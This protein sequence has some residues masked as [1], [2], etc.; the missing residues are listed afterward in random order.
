MPSVGDVVRV[1]LIGD[2]NSADQFITSWEYKIIAA[3]ANNSEL[4]ADLLVLFAAIANVFKSLA[5]ALQAWRSIRVQNLT[6]GEVLGI[7][8]FPAAVLGNVTGDPGARQISALL[9]FPT[10]FSRVVLRKYPCPLAEGRLTN[11]GRVDAAVMADVITN[12]TPYTLA[13]YVGTNGTY[14][15]GY[16]SQ[17]LGQ[18]VVPIAVFSTVIP[19]SQGRRRETVGV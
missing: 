13:D 19:S 14:Q 4:I 2:T 1:D 8:D 11:V 18:W 15:Y 17:H 7:Y 3:P 12:L 6:T 5:T 16:Q 9:S 10:G